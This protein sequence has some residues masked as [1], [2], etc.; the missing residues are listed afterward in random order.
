MSAAACPS[1]QP[2]GNPARPP[3]RAAA[4]K[5]RGQPGTRAACPSDRSGGLATCCARGSPVHVGQ[6]DA[7]GPTLRVERAARE[8]VAIVRRGRQRTRHGLRRR[9]AGHLSAQLVDAGAREPGE[10]AGSE[11]AQVLLVEL[12]AVEGARSGPVSGGGPARVA[13]RGRRA[14]RRLRLRGRGRKRGGLADGQN[15]AAERA[16]DERLL[17]ISSPAGRRPAR[18][19][20]RG[21]RRGPARRDG[22]GG[23]R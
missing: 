15:R 1:R 8:P 17:A 16:V 11:E 18:A 14:D 13:H 23:R 6:I 12:E 9:R 3:H 5:R 22:A 4:D 20:R 7:G 2:A 19:P 21:A 10:G